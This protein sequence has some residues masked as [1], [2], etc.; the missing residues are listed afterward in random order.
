MFLCTGAGIK[1]LLPQPLRRLLSKVRV[2]LTFPHR[3]DLNVE[4]CEV[5][6]SQ[7]SKECAIFSRQ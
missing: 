5:P 7:G 6:P 2:P 1:I 3:D 4:G